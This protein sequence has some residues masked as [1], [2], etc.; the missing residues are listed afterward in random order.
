[1][2]TLN[3]LTVPLSAQEGWKLDKEKN[4]IL[5]YTRGAEDCNIREA[6]AF[7]TINSSDL[8]RVAD[9][10]LRFQQHSNWLYKVEISRILEKVTDN[11]YVI[12]Y[13]TQ[14]VWPVAPRDVILRYKINTS[15]NQ[16]TIKTETE[17]D[18][19][20]ER[21]EFVRVIEA[22]SEWVISRKGKNQIEVEYFNHTNPGGSL[23]IWM[24]NLAAAKIP[25]MSLLNLKRTIEDSVVQ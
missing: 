13:A 7:V 12:Y 5:V 11:E 24:A 3:S 25:Y 19:I 20:N 17:P 16:I 6:R 15:S 9:Y 14:S 4:D 23:P 1:M 21:E 22:Y 10:F 8:S 2:L 18:Y